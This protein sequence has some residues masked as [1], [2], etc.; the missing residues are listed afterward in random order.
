VRLRAQLDE[1]RAA[2]RLR[3]V[4]SAMEAV[5]LDLL[6]VAAG[7]IDS[8]AVTAQLDAARRL[9]EQV[10]EMMKV[11]RGAELTARRTSEQR[12]VK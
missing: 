12:E 1:P 5:R 7:T 8:G 2:D 3:T 4:V 9:G 10:D 11:E 6:R